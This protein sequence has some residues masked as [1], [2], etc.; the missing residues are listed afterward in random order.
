MKFSYG[1]EARLV[2]T[3]DLKCAYY[4]KESYD[5]YERL[6]PV[7]GHDDA[8]DAM[9]WAEMAYVGS[10]YEHEEFTIEMVEVL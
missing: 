7:V 6:E 3:K 1:V 9:C 10:D 8:E 2:F 4:Y 5:L